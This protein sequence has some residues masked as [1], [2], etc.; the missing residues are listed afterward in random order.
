MKLVVIHDRTGVKSVG[1]G[2]ET[3]VEIGGL[4]RFVENLQRF[5]HRALAPLTYWH[6]PRN[7][8]RKIK[9]TESKYA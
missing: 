2:W 7:S 3:L 6:D 9:N 1:N 4:A 5:H 8:T